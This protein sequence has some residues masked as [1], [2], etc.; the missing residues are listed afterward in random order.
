MIPAR[1]RPGKPVITAAVAVTALIGGAGAALAATSSSSSPSRAAS[2]AGTA[3]ATPSP[4]PSSSRCQVKLPRRGFPP[5]MV[6]FAIRAL[7][8]PLGLGP[9]GAIHGQFVAP[10]QGGGYQTIDTQRG[11][12]TAVSTGSITVKSSDGYTKSYL[13]T[14]STNVD[15]Q[16]AGIGSVKTGQT[17]SVLATVSGSSATATQ[18]VDF[19]LPLKPFAVPKTLVPGFRQLLPNAPCA[20]WSFTKKPG[21]APS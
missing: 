15:A 14:S 2:R 20:S 8:V 13:V 17:V 3:V 16:R 21:Q 18:I 5:P 11:T 10:K 12:V 1:V 6:G 19:A 9:F 4:S 7:P